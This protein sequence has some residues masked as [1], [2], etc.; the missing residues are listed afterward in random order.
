[1]GATLPHN[2]PHIEISDDMPTDSELHTV[3]RGL[4]NGQAAGATGMRAKHIKG[5]LDEIQRDEKAA[6]ENSGREGADPRA[7]RRWR[8]FVKLI[9]S[10]WERGNIPER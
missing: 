4:K 9:Q 6:R 8:I 7:S 3:L 10:I 1:M 5:W 2:F